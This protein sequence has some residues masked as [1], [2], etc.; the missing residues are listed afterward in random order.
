MPI[1][2]LGQ[3]W[4][5]IVS[6]PDLGTLAYFAL[7]ASLKLSSVEQ[8]SKGLGKAVP[9]SDGVW[10]EEPLVG[11][12]TGIWYQELIC[13]GFSLIVLLSGLVALWDI[14][15]AVDISVA[16]LVDL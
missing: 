13:Y 11:E 5:L 8:L 6:I 10:E 15:K 4:Y 2:I 1:G 9:H 16:L 12:S 7:G 3:L 14:H